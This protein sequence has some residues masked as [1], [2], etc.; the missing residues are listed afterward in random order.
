M[1]LPAKFKSYNTREFG[2]SNVSSGSLLDM[3]LSK[4]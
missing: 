1:K 3:D 2:I 4:V